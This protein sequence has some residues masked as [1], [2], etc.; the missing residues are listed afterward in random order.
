MSQY[1]IRTGATIH[2]P[3]SIAQIREFA[4]RG[5]LKPSHKLSADKEKWFTASTVKGLK[6]IT[7][8]PPAQNATSVAVETETNNSYELAP[9]AESSLGGLFEVQPRSPTPSTG[10]ESK[11]KPAPNEVLLRSDF[12]Y[13][14]FGTVGMI[15]ATVTIIGVFVSPLIWWTDWNT[16]FKTGKEGEVWMWQS[17]AIFAWPAYVIISFVVRVVT[18]R[19]IRERQYLKRHS[20]GKITIVS[21]GYWFGRPLTEKSESGYTRLETTELL[22]TYSLRLAGSNVEPLVLKSAKTE[23]KLEKWISKYENITGL[24]VVR[25]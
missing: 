19:P 13:Y 5:R 2:G 11:F 3:F 21:R 7:T 25:S 4:L 23:Q 10:G 14:Y 6:F 22:G 17:A 1:W 12:L 24:S 8:S 9:V 18:R 20:N 15:I 16:K